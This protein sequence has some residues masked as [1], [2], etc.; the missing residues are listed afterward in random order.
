MGSS[1]TDT[2]TDALARAVAGP[3][4]AMLHRL[5]CHGVEHVPREGPAILAANHQSFYD[6]ILICLGA[7][8]H[9]AFLAWDYYYR[10]PLV[11]PLM[12]PFHPVPVDLDSPGPSALTG[13]L[14]A[15]RQ[16]CLCGIFPEGGRTPDG[17][18][19]E[20]QP[21]V[22]ALA[23][24]SGALIIPVTISGAYRAWPRT[25]TLPRAAPIS[26]YFGEPMRPSIPPGAS[27]AQRRRQITWQLMRRIAEGFGPLG[28]PDL[29]EA[30][31]RRL[32]RLRNAG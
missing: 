32:D 17:L 14:R 29:A 19:Q 13:L 23:L 2:R 15:L 26:V 10:H 11:G 28:R 1:A 7:R 30:C 3:A 4:F 12:R 20:P 16:G 25:R 9:V 31:L 22:G 21:G 6:P 5:R 24:R 8:R 27:V 18:L